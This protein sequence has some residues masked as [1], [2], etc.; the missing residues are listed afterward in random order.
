M[1]KNL[2]IA[3]LL[4]SGASFAQF[5]QANEPTIGST[6]LMHVCDSFVT[7]YAGTT[8][9]GVTWDYSNIQGVLGEV[10]TIEVLDPSATPEGANFAGSTKALDI[11]NFITTYIS[12][13]ASARNSQ[14]FTFVEP[15]FGTINVILDT[16]DELLMNYPY[17]V[18]N[19]LVDAVSGTASASLGDF[20]ATGSA[21]TTVDGSGT[22]ILNS[23]TTH[24]NVLR[25]KITDNI[26]ANTGILGVVTMQREQYEYYDLA[27]SSMPLF[28]HA[29]LVIT[30]SGTPQSLNLVLSSAQPDTYLSVANNELAGVAVYPNPANELVTIKGLTSE[31]TAQIVDL[32]GKVV[33]SA[34]VNAGVD[35]IAISDLNAGVYVMTISTENGVKTQ[36][37]VVE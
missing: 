8:G 4:L 13:T 2:L 36:R 17:A 25:F 26:S 11:P 33:R 29:Q 19:S 27:N 20:P 34:A 32:Q 31:G 30:I 12:S 9:T 24:N 22:L 21:Q 16:D 23:T 28:I 6:Q 18:T 15:S 10:K 37:L 1:K 3:S 5:T 14:G 7:N 35:T